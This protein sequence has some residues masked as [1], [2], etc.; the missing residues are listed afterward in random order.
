ME[1]AE[2]M[3]FINKKLKRTLM[4]G[5]APRGEHHPVLAYPKGLWGVSLKT[6]IG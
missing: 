5:G 4:F 6:G 2:K 1:Q 3:R